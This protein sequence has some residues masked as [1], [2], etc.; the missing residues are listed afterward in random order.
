MLLETL[1]QPLVFLM[2]I[3]VGFLSGIVF[4]FSNF[5]WKTTNK[6]KNF[7][8]ILD[9]FSTLIVF[10]LFFLCIYL[11][12]F[13]E[14]RVYEIFVFFLFFSIQRLTL[15]KLVEKFIDLCYI[16]CNEIFKKINTRKKGKEDDKKSS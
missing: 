1:S 7:K 5:I 11:F 8:H 2:L 10:S 9:F 14:I 12:N 13:G 4:D 15:G 6:N 3:I 16:K